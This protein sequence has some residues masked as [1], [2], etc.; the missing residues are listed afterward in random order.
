[1]RALQGKERPSNPADL[2]SGGGK[3]NPR[4]VWLGRSVSLVALL[5]IYN[6]YHFLRNFVLLLGGT[7][8]VA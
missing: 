6:L 8:Y 3:K 7:A 1:M 4:E 5:N 2:H